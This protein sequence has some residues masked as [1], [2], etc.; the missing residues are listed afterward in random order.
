M[1]NVIQ[2]HLR[3]QKRICH[4]AWDIKKQPAH[5]ALGESLRFQ[6]C[7][8]V[9]FICFCADLPASVPHPGNH[10]SPSDRSRPVNAPSA[11]RADVRTVDV[12]VRVMAAGYTQIMGHPLTLYLGRIFLLTKPNSYDTLISL[13]NCHRVENA[14][15]FACTSL[16]L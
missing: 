4:N 7:K 14:D 11:L 3:I 16:G 8:R 6:L 2:T 9:V 12:A 1:K 5:P 13:S 10:S 15:A